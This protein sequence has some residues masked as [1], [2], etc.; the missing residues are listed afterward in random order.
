M[1]KRLCKLKRHD[2]ADNLGT[3]HKLVAQP[4]FLCRSCARSSSD[5]S[6]LCKPHSINPSP[7]LKPA[8]QQSQTLSGKDIKKSKKAV[9]KQKK[10]QKKL[11]KVLK[12]QSKLTKKHQKLE[13]QYAKINLALLSSQVN[14]QTQP[15][16]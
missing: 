4:R 1:T 12:K 14:E 15:L 16:H 3:I 11:A 10:H 8:E 6:V 5:K 9:K 13:K 7:E 2:I